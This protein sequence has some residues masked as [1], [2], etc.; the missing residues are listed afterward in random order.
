[1][2]ALA[3][4]APAPAPDRRSGRGCSGR[5]P[6]D[7]SPPAPAARPGRQRSTSPPCTCASPIRSLWLSKGRDCQALKPH[8]MKRTDSSAR[9]LKLDRPATTITSR[10]PFCSAE[11]VKPKPA[12]AVWPVLSPSAPGTRPSRGLRLPWVIGAVAAHRPAPGEFPHPVIFAVELRVAAHR[13]DRE[14]G[15]VARGGVGHAIV[16]PADRIAPVGVG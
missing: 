10:R 2:L 4:S 11:P 8:C 5:G 14:P 6:A 13:R 16:R 7:R 15:E 1:M 12:S 3:R 9:W